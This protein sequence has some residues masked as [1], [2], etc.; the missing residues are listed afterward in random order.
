MTGLSLGETTISPFLRQS[1]FQTEYNANP[2]QYDTMPIQYNTIQYN[3]IEYNTTPI[4]IGNGK[5]SYGESER[6]VGVPL[7]N[8]FNSFHQNSNANTKTNTNTITNSKSESKMQ[9]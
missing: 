6:N 4:Q 7:L 1:K 2:V 9:M 8:F 3:T 5:Q